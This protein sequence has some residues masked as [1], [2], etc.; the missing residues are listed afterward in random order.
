MD[1]KQNLKI[2]LGLVI[3]FSSLFSCHAKG[4]KNEISFLIPKGSNCYELVAADSFKHVERYFFRDL[5]ANRAG[6]IIDNCIIS[7][8]DS[9]SM[10]VRLPFESTLSDILWY[11]G[12][13]YF[14]TNSTINAMSLDG[15]VHPII[16]SD[17]SISSF[18]VDGE[19]VLFS[20]DSLLLSY[21]LKTEKFECL[22][23]SHKQ[24]SHIQGTHSSVF[25][26][27]GDKLFLLDK[28]TLYHLYS[29]DSVIRSFAVYPDGSVFY[30]TKSGIYYLDPNYHVALI[31]DY[32]AMEL[33]IIGDDLFIVFAN[34]AG[35]LITNIANYGSLVK[36]QNH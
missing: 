21:S 9:L 4:E 24:I 6:V 8:N 26:S 30:S 10:P 16:H 27:S 33:S 19:N 13:C 11:D 28:N 1:S 25:F 2:V 35:Y 20:T 5:H 7:L 3:L 22:L 29:A 36:A 18:C 14:C 31:A 15:V 23:D 12:I 34:K 17:G 32:P